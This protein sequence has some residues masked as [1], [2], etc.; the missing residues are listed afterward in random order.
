MASSAGQSNS[1]SLRYV[2]VTDNAVAPAKR[3]PGAA[4]YDLCAAESV[5]LS[6]GARACVSTGLKLG[7]PEGCYGRIA[8]RSGLALRHGIDVG[9]GVIDADY[10]GIVGVII[11]NHSLSDFKIS[12]GNRI[13]QLVLER[14]NNVGAVRVDSLEDTFRGQGGFGS[15]GV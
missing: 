4:G 7:V 15:T 14:I 1:S 6:P 11:F 2:L 8:P 3:S 5:I 12:A 9:G 10:R 13:A